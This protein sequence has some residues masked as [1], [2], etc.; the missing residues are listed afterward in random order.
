MGLGF[1]SVVS[2]CRDLLAGILEA[3]SVGLLQEMLAPVGPGTRVALFPDS[4][5]LGG[6]LISQMKGLNPSSSNI[7]SVHSLKN[8]H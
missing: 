6:D 8:I 1:R 5:H 3:P 4:L 2:P 7:L